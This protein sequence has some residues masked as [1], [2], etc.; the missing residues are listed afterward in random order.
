[1]KYYIFE[2]FD[3]ANQRPVFQV[4]G[5]DNDY[6][7]EWHNNK[8]EAQAELDGL[9]KTM[10]KQAEIEARYQARESWAVEQAE[11]AQAELAQAELAK[12]ILNA[13]TKFEIVVVL[14]WACYQTWF[15][16]QVL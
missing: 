1:M 4:N 5:R 12:P 3:W 14:A 15:L 13:R 8:Q 2:G 10:A 16:S 7:G 9:V 11:L 6:C